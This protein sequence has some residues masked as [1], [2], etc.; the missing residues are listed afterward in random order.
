MARSWRLQRLL[1][2]D[3]A[4][5]FENPLAEIHDLTSARPMNRRNRATLDDR[6]ERPM[7]VVKPGWL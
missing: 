5:F 4:E 1:G 3:D 6:S 7:R 2:D